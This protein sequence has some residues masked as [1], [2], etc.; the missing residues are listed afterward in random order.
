MAGSLNRACLLGNLGRDPEIRNTQGGDR[1]AS[2]S[3][4]TTETWKDKTSGEQK[5]ATEWHRITV[6]GPLA[7]VVEKYTR[8]GSK[9]YIEGQL[10]TRKWTD[11]DGAEKY[12]TE[13]VLRPFNGTLVLLDGRPGDASSGDG[14]RRQGA[15]G[16]G[17]DGGGAGAPRGNAGRGR[18]TA[19]DLSDDI[20]FA[21]EAR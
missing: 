4:A 10:Q 14:E 20:P 15:S 2:L 7:D 17:W 1:V 13:I 3:L 9:L 19:D 11:K 16:G 6:W 18:S 21:P 5:S 12:S 8:K